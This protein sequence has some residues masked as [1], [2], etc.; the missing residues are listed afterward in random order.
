MRRALLSLT[1]FAVLLPEVVFACKCAGPSNYDV[2]FEGQVMSVTEDAANIQT[3]RYH[4]VRFRIERVVAGK[5]QNEITVYTAA[6]LLCGMVYRVG[7]TYL[8]HA[9]D[10]GY[11]ETKYCYGRQAK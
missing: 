6:P 11:F 3:D 10:K 1:A 7:E 8:V 5:K 4:A 2:V 9:L